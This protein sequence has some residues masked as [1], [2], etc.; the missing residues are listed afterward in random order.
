MGK[1]RVLDDGRKK[2]KAKEPK[3][4][5]PKG[6]KKPK[7]NT[8]KKKAQEKDFELP[9]GFEIEFVEREGG[10]SKKA[11]KDKYFVTPEGKRLRSIAEVEAYTAKQ[12]A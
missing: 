2:P 1:K 6:S 10:K 9:E 4:L 3:K 8:S 11:K 12:Q 5:Q 7:A